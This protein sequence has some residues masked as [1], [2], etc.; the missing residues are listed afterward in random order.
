MGE[1]VLL[2]VAAQGKP[3]QESGAAGGTEAA[4]QD[5]PLHSGAATFLTVCRS[6]CVPQ[7]CPILTS[8]QLA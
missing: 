3:S 8:S 1:P 2:R 6:L 4:G 5:C 7:I